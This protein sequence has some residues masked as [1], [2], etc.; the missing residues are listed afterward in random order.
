MRHYVAG[1]EEREELNASETDLDDTIE[2]LHEAVDLKEVVAEVL[3]LLIPDY[4]RKEGLPPLS[5]TAEPEGAEP[6]T[7]ENTKPFASLAQLK[8]KLQKEQ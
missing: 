4:P 5:A 7:E 6:L 1:F 3:G 8:D 2:P